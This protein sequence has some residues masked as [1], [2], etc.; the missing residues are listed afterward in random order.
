MDIVGIKAWQIGLEAQSVIA[1]ACC[2][3][4]SPQIPVSCKAWSASAAVNPACRR[5]MSSTMARS[6]SGKLDS[7]A[8]SSSVKTSAA[9][10]G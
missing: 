6:L 9:F 3:A 7:T 10:F 8:R 2:P 4:A 1:F 5:I